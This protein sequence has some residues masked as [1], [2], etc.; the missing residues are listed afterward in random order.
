MKYLPLIWSGLWRKKTRTWLTLLSIVVAFLLFGMLQGVNA[1]FNRGVELANVDRLIVTN[2]IS[3]TE[4]LPYAYLAQIQTVPGVKVVTHST[5]FGGYYQDPKNFVFANPVELDSYL[6]AVPEIVTDPD[7]VAAWKRSRTAAL[8]GK[9]VMDK[10]GWKIGDRVS[11][12]STIWPQRDTGSMDWPMDIV[13]VY[14]VPEDPNNEQSVLFHYD[15]FDEARQFGNGSVGWYLLSVNDP[16]QAANVAQAIDARFANSPNETRTQSE[17][18]FSQSFLKQ[19]GDIQFIVTSIL[20]AVFFTLLFLTGNTMMQSV[21]DRIPELAVLKT[22]G[23]SDLGV[24]ALVVIESL[25]L[26]LVAAAIG[27]GLSSLA[28][29]AMKQ[30]VGEASLPLSVT[31]EGLVVAVVLAVLIALLPGLT[32]QRLKI[33]DA[34]AGR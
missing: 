18:E 21:R 2:R 24:L 11:L 17:K 13:G 1:A 6:E 23:F 7:Q 19:F 26:C 20:G 16:N 9:V 10:Y 28:F 3:I 31:L 30:I 29:P 12:H 34:L 8:A 4:Q 22:L 5:W 15:Y 25:L 32:A 14:T 27:L 33:V